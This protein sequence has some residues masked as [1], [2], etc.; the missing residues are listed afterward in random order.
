MRE[1]NNESSAD[2]NKPGHRVRICG[3]CGS[4]Q[5]SQWRRHWDRKH[6]GQPR[7]EEGQ[8]KPSISALAS[9]PGQPQT[10]VIPDTLL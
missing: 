5:T 3:E 6:P 7:Y 2:S 1:V 8:A 10:Y 4:E 9:Q